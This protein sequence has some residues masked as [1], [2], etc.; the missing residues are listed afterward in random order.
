MTVHCCYE[1]LDGLSIRNRRN[2][3]RQIKVNKKMPEAQRTSSKPPLTVLFTKKANTE[4]NSV[5]VT[6]YLSHVTG[7]MR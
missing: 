2:G 3:Y 5:I 4:V 7:D 1:K 6:V